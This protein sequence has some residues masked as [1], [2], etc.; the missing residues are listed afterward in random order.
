VAG[1]PQGVAPNGPGPVEA[2]VQSELDGLTAARPGLMQT[3]LALARI[4]DTPRAVS[5]QPAAARTLAALLDKLHSVSAG[6]RRGR[7]TLVKSMTSG[8]PW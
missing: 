1:L 6:S 4:M 8:H 3:A 5:S 2:A 7:L